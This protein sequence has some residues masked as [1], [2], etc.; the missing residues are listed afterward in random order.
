MSHN[1]VQAPDRSDKL[2]E[3]AEIECA[4]AWDTWGD[5]MS[6]PSHWAL[7]F[8]RDSSNQSLAIAEDSQAD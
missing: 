2:L 3:Q 5:P 4:A 1:D 8:Q 7:V 6:A